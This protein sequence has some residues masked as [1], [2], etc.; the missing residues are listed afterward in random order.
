MTHPFDAAV[1]LDATAPDTFAARTSPAYWNMVGPFGGITAATVLRAVESHPARLGEPLSLTVNYAAAVAEGPFTVQA[2]PVRTN[3]STQHW[4]VDILQPGP[5]GAP[6][7]TTTA[8]AVTAAR[9][10]T[11]SASDMPVPEAPPPETVAQRDVFRG[12][13]WIQRYAMRPLAG[14]LPQAW[15][16]AESGDSLTR[17]W[18]RDEPPRP[19]DFA[20]L[21]A[22]CDVFYPRVW[23]RRAL[24]VPAGTVSLTVYFHAGSD[25]LAAVGSGWLLAQAR[26]QEFR[27]G[28]FDQNAQL[29][30]EAGRLLATSHQVVYYK[31]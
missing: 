6:A 30:N 23:L 22:L 7:V 1:A 16:G 2:R 15:D 12:V 11:W 4:T 14:A 21:T 8:T 31:E 18:L 25:A 27:N 17:L 26:A 9:R 3:R 24:M 20:A 13:A 5:G 19:L 28:F 29:W 10:T